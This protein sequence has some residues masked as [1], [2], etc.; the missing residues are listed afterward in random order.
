M[1]CQAVRGDDAAHGRGG[2]GVSQRSVEPLAED[3]AQRPGSHSLTPPHRTRPGRRC[4]R[5]G[6]VTNFTPVFLTYCPLLSFLHEPSWE[7]QRKRGVHC[8]QPPWLHSPSSSLFVH[9]VTISTGKRLSCPGEEL[10]ENKNNIVLITTKLMS[11]DKNIFKKICENSSKRKSQYIC[12]C[13]YAGGWMCWDGDVIAILR[14]SD[15]MR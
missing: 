14:V 13:A 10:Q 1:P 5:L 6:Y 9:S 11:K 2:G 3:R 15:N 7:P 8:H 12:V 4:L